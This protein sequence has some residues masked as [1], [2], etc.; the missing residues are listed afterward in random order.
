MTTIGNQVTVGCIERVNIPSLNIKNL[1]AKI[2][3]GAYTGALHC[4]DIKVVRR[5]GRR[6]L[7]FRPL[8][9]SRKVYEFE[10]FYRISVTSAS[11]HKSNR[12]AIPIVLEIAGRNYETHIGVTK[13]KQLR[14][15]ML[16]G[17]RFLREYNIIVD[18]RRNQDADDKKEVSSVEQ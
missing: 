5:G 12:W 3:T 11:G 14:K 13:R 4:E 2:D 7:R 8:S 16:I 1:I 9:A 15:Q 17:R 18:V 10:D 6:F